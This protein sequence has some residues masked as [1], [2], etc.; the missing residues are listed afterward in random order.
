LGK[1]DGH[2]ALFCRRHQGRVPYQFRAFGHRWK[3]LLHPSCG[4]GFKNA[5]S[6]S[7]PWLLR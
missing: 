6:I 3:V 4:T 7:P 2:G 1:V 5:L